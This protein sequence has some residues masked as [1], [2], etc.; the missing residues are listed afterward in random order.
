MRAC[1]GFRYRS[2]KTTMMGIRNDELKLQFYEY[3]SSWGLKVR[4]T[5]VLNVISLQTTGKQPMSFWNFLARHSSQTEKIIRKDFVILAERSPLSSPTSSL[6]LQFVYGSCV[7][8]CIFLRATSWGFWAF[9][10]ASEIRGWNMAYRFLNTS[11][12]VNN[13]TPLWSCCCAR[14][15][16]FVNSLLDIILRV[17]VILF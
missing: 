3:T 1:V 8:R 16:D 4:K 15:M 9:G 13:F 11:S 17:S 7:K 12:K 10:P 6:L 14:L 2:I 5:T